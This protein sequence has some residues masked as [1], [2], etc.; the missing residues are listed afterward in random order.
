M[1]RLC[2][3]PCHRSTRNHI[4][5]CL[6]RSRALSAEHLNLEVL[7]QSVAVIVT[8]RSLERHFHIQTA[9]LSRFRSVIGECVWRECRLQV[10][11]LYVVHLGV[12]IIVLLLTRR[13]DAE[14][15]FSCI[16]G[17]NVIRYRFHLIR[18]VLWQ[19]AYETCL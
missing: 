17:D 12:D 16:L 7:L 1:E 2:V 18:R 3:G 4:G 15:V 9:V 6:Y 10:S 11:E 19:V 8:G 14:A 5:E 13:V